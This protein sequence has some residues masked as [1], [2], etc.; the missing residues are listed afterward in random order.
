MRVLDLQTIPF[1]FLMCFPLSVYVWSVLLIEGGFVRVVPEMPWEFRLAARMTSAKRR[2]GLAAMSV[3]GP[4][5]PLAIINCP[6]PF[7]LVGLYGAVGSIAAA[8]YVVVHLL[9]LARIR[10]AIRRINRQ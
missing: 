10:R 8:A 1:L 5:I 4:L 7:F 6:V 3:A 2:E 9:W